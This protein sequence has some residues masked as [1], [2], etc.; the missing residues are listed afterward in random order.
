[1][2]GTLVSYKVLRPG[3]SRPAIFNTGRRRKP[4]RQADAAD[5]G[6]KLV[7]GAAPAKEQD[8]PLPPPPAR[9]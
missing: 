5:E 6:Q 2:A 3:A 1:M 8:N 9:P 7:A 4:R